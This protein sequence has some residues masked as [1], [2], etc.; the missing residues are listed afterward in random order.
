MRKNDLIQ[1][2][3]TLA[4]CLVLITQM[5]VPTG[6]ANIVP[7]LGGPRDSLPPILV[8]ARPSDSTTNFN[9]RRIVFEFNEFVQLDNISENLLVSPTPKINPTVE[10]KLR[11]VTVNIKDTL[12]PNTTYTY[13]FGN[14]IKDVNESNILK[15]FSYSFSTGPSIDSFQLS[16]S[17]IVAQT[18]KPD[19]TLIAVLYKNPDD[20][21]VAKESPRY[22]ARLDREGKFRFRNLPAGVFY[23]YAFEGKGGSKRYQSKSQLFAFADS[24]IV[25]GPKQE[26]VILYAFAEEEEAPKTDRPGITRS[27]GLRGTGAAADKRLKLETNLDAG[28]QDLLKPLEV[29][30]RAAPIKEYDSTK[31]IFADEKLNLITNYKIVRDTGNTKL[32]LQYSWTENSSYYLIVDKDFATDTAGRKLAKNDTLAFKT[33]KQSAYGELRLRFPN[34]DLSL[35]P[36]LQFVQN[37]QVAKSIPLSSKEYN[38]KLFVPGEY[39]LRIVFDENKN[40]KWDPGQFFGTRRQPEKVL[41]ISRKLTVKSNWENEIDITL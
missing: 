21:A 19:S 33:K 36:I 1:G 7:P 9:S 2:L 27:T 13:N 3:T 23:L 37:G 12:E 31:I 11:T 20:S 6:C 22:I 17:V 18:G 30:F 40:G 26:N 4:A 15:N 8:N 39:D 34:L 25:T 35:N 28:E 5:V 29:Y 32:S 10:S 14:A 16:G 41:A 24:A 38:A